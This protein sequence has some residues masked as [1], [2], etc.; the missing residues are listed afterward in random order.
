MDTGLGWW[1][2]LA[3]GIGLFLAG[4]AAGITAAR[5]GASGK[6]FRRL[7]AALREARERE[8]HYRESVAAHFGRTSEIFRDLSGQY[9]SLYTHLAEGA[10]TLCTDDVPAVRFEPPLTLADS[11]AAED[12]ERDAGGAARDEP[13]RGTEERP[14]PHSQ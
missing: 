8:Q 4:L 9:R 14:E 5:L 11:R 7:D 10:R 6:R 2:Q 3:I 1:T 12:R 13:A